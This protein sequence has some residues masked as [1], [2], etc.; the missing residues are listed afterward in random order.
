LGHRLTVI[1]LSR[2]VRPDDQERGRIQPQRHFPVGEAPLKTEAHCGA[3]RLAGEALSILQIEESTARNGTTRVKD[4]VGSLRI[5][6]APAEPAAVT[7]LS[8]TASVITT[9]V[10][11]RGVRESR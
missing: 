8:E 2:V 3:A 4:G 1:I 11:P 10:E 6:T 7:Y 5:G 9:P